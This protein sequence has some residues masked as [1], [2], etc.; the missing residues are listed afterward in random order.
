MPSEP[1]NPVP[2][3]TDQLQEAT[4][5]VTDALERMAKA[6]EGLAP[7][8][9]K[10]VSEGIRLHP[11]EAA[12]QVPEA[13]AGVAQGAGEA[14]GDVAQ[15]AGHAAAAVP[16]VATD[17]LETGGAAGQAVVSKAKRFTLRKRR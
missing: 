1:A 9:E 12:K 8:L 7:H 4:T 15:G 11:V 2:D 10:L 6:F 3:T 14:A 5:D 16:A 17:T 13:A